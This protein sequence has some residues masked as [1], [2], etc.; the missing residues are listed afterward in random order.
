MTGTAWRRRCSGCAPSP[1]GKQAAG[2]RRAAGS[3]RFCNRLRV[4]LPG[5]LRRASQTDDEERS[6]QIAG[7]TRCRSG[8]QVRPAVAAANRRRARSASA[9]GCR[10]LGRA[11]TEPSGRVASEM[12]E[13][14]NHTAASANFCSSSLRKCRSSNAGGRLHRVP[15][16][17]QSVHPDGGRNETAGQF[18]KG[19]RGTA[20]VQTVGSS[21]RG[22][23]PAGRRPPTDLEPSRATGRRATQPLSAVTGVGVKRQYLVSRAAK[24]VIGRKRPALQV[25]RASRA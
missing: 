22:S 19:R 4:Q 3:G 7:S 21:Q 14:G 6:R 12:D 11:G 18:P 1:G 24:R 9:A 8:D 10:S 23:T 17:V 25:R 16:C 13:L 20:R 5:E 15:R 2:A